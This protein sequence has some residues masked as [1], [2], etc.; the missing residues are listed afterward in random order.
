MKITLPKNSKSSNTPTNYVLLSDSSGSM[1]GSIDTL[2]ETIAAVSALMTD[3]DTIT[4]GDFSSYGDFDFF[5]RGLK[6]SQDITALVNKKIRARGLTC[7]TQA[8][9]ALPKILEDLT[10]LTGN[11]VFSF[12]FLSDGYPNDNSSDSAIQ[13]ACQGLKGKFASAL[14]CGF[15]GYYGRPTLLAMAETI[16]G[17]M[18]HISDFQEMKKSYNNFFKG[19]KTKKNIPIDQKY[20]YVWQVTATDIVLLEQNKDNSVDVF[21]SKDDTKLFAVNNSELGKLAEIKDASF[22]YSLAYVLSQK[23]K[24]NLGVA[25]LRQ[26]GALNDAAMLIKAFTVSQKGIAENELKI[27]AIIG[28]EVVAQVATPK[29][30]IAQFLADIEDQS[31]KVKLDLSK[32]AY[33]SITKKAEDVSKVTFKLDEGLATIT[34]VIGNENRPNVSLQTVRTGKLTEIKDADLKARVEAFNKANPSLAI[35]LPIACSTFKNYNLVANGDFNFDELTLV[36][37]AGESM[38]IDLAKEIDLFDENAKT[39]NIKDFAA[40]YKQLIEEKAHASVLAFYIKK[41]SPVKDIDD[42]RVKLHGIEG[43]ALLAEMGV[44]KVFRYA[45]KGGSTERKPDDDYIPFLEISAQLKGAAKISATES[46]K[47]YLNEI[48]TDPKVKKPKQN[49]GDVICF[50]LFKKYDAMLA[51]LGNDIFVETVQTTLRGVQ[52]TVALLK[53]KVSD[54]KF[55]LMTT[56]SWFEGVDKADKFEYDGLVIE[57]AEDKEYI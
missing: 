54:Q 9:N 1:W 41:Y 53:A 26:A 25:V 28:G 8:L 11:S 32:S 45:A 22:V 30:A 40:I 20:D 39:V 21:D 44:D 57:T 49:P 5:A 12:F 23:N 31:G 42:Q 24:A 29:L 10:A 34:D 14:I 46:Y 7:Y 35:N 36:N 6:K 43:A 2:K 33:R 18:N 55:Y 48:S 17:Q 38:R 4:I 50:P 13:K 52:K 3:E 19:K 51:K 37:E 16:G 15:G 47:K 27:S 56:N